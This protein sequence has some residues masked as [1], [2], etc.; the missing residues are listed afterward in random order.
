MKDTC[1]KHYLISPNTVSYASRQLVIKHNIA[2]HAAW[3][4]PATLHRLRQSTFLARAGEKLYCIAFVKHSPAAPL[5]DG[6]WRL[7]EWSPYNIF[8]DM[9][10]WQQVGR[11]NVLQEAEDWICALHDNQLPFDNPANPYIYQAT[12][13]RQNLEEQRNAWQRLPLADGTGYKYRLHEKHC[14]PNTYLEIA[15]VGKKWVFLLANSFNGQRYTSNAMSLKAA[16]S[17]AMDKRYA[18]QLLAHL[19]IPPLYSKGEQVVVINPTLGNAGT[20]G[21]RGVVVDRAYV[22]AFVRL[23]GESLV[24]Q[25]YCHHIQSLE[26]I[27]YQ[28]HEAQA[29][30]QGVQVGNAISP[31][32]DAADT[33]QWFAGWPHPAADTFVLGYSVDSVLATMHKGDLWLSWQTWGIYG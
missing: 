8:A 21:K 26:A 18:P 27:L 4:S 5:G 20:R 11:F 10:S 17:L 14:L 9:D 23:E 13:L 7:Y 33:R 15:P 29:T 28:V 19:G 12:L 3:E 16:K 6:E 22:V 25:Y 32:M 24:R 1:P 31:Y 2:A 30:E